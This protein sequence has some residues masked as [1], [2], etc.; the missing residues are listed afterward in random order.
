MSNGTF[1]FVTYSITVSGNNTG[2][3]RTNAIAYLGLPVVNLTYAGSIG[4][5]A[6]LPGASSTTTN[7]LNVNVQSGSD[8]VSLTSGSTG[9]YGDINFTGF[10]G[11]LAF[12][13]PSASISMYGSLTLSSTMTM[14]SQSGGLTLSEISSTQQITTAGK[15]LDFP[16]TQSG[17]GGTIQLQDNLTMGSTRTFNL[18][19]GTLDLNNNTLNAGLLSSSNSNVRSILFGTTGQI[20]L[21]GN[22]VTLLTISNSANLTTTGNKTV[23]ATYS[24]STGT[25]TVNASLAIL[26]TNA[27]NVNVTAGSDLLSLQNNFLNLDLT[28]FSGTLTSNVR[29]IFYNFTIPSGVTITDGANVTTLAGTTGTSTITTNGVSLLFP[30]TVDGIGGT[31][32]FADALTQGADKNFIL[33]NGTVKLKNSATSTVGAFSTTGTNQKFLQSSVAGTQATLSQVSGAVDTSYL[34]IK[35]INATGGATWNSFVDQSNVDAGNN[36]GW[37]FGI[38]PIIGGTEYTYQL[39]SFTQPRRF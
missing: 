20:N 37:D 25:R 18:T 19:A 34:T 8:I 3:Y 7:Q 2:V 12:S 36:D 14:P 10:S 6:I 17:L 13:S 16:V 38:S 27:I 9:K 31:F 29:K 21:T 24:G 4:T 28:G 32:L 35:D 30:I 23:N 39:R 26:E 15:T 22:A 5:R 1:D 11:S 33:T